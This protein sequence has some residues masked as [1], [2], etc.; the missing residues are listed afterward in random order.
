MTHGSSFIPPNVT[1]PDPQAAKVVALIFSMFM[2]IL[3]IVF[4]GFVCVDFVTEMADLPWKFRDPQ[5]SLQDVPLFADEETIE[6]SNHPFE[7]ITPKHRTQMQGPDIVVIYT[8]RDPDDPAPL[9]KLLIDNAPLLWE[10]QF[11][12]NT[13]FARLHLQAGLHRVRVEESESEFFVETW[14]SPMQSPEEWAWNRPHPNTDKTNRC[15]DCHER[16]HQAIGAWKGIG[17]CFGCHDE[18]EHAARHADIPSS[19][20]RC[21]RCHTIH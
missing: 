17:S 19:S 16:S 20:N 15:T 12:N 8:Q 13:W 1:P 6:E 2:A 14:D 3:M 5:P 21:L 18:E 11:G 9:P 7:L 10:E 4:I